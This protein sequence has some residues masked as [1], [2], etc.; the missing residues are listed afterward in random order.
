MS[1]SRRDFVRVPVPAPAAFRWRRSFERDRANVDGDKHRVG[2]LALVVVE[3]YDPASRWNHDSIDPAIVIGVVE[4]SGP[5]HDVDYVFMPTQQSIVAEVGDLFS[6]VAG[7]VLGEN[8]LEPAPFLTLFLP[9]RKLLG[10]ESGVPG[11]VFLPYCLFFSCF[12]SSSELRGNRRI[13][14]F[15]GAR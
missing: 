4:T 5:A 13:G 7:D 14:G 11:R 2:N 10:Y 1:T 8:G 9:G 12:R 6:C 15:S 3:C